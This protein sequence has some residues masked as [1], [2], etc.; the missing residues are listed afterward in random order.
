M[1]SMAFLFFL[2]LTGG[3]LILIYGVEE[4]DVLINQLRE[5]FL[6]LVYRWDTDPRASRVLKQI[7]EYVS[8]KMTLE[9]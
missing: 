2:E 8:L 3:I 6:E 4:S 1:T 7:M 5:T 9:V